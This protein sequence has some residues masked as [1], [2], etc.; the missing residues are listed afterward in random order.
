MSIFWPASF[1]KFSWRCWTEFSQSWKDLRKTLRSH[2]NLQS[3]TDLSGANIGIHS[4]SRDW[5]FWMFMMSKIKPLMKK[6][7]A[8]LERC[9]NSI[10]YLH[11]KYQKCDSKVRIYHC[12]TCIKY[13]YL[14]LNCTDSVV[15]ISS[16]VPWKIK[17]EVDKTFVRTK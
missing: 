15:L 11:K 6:R 14:Y 13:I 16:N 5:L 17:N 3:L 7:S 4:N 1:V 2:E 8:V 10:F 12:S 9:V